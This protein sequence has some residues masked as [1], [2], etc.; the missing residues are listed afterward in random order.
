MAKPDPE[1]LYHYTDSS[2]LLG[3]LGSPRRLPGTHNHQ[4]F[5]VDEDATFGTLWATDA[6]YLNDSHEIVFGASILAD[7][8]DEQASVQGRT[9]LAAERL[10]ALA[11]DVRKSRFNMTRGENGR[12]A[13]PY[14]ACFCESGDLLSQWRGYGANGGGYAVGFRRS[15]LPNFCLLNEG[16]LKSHPEHALM[17]MYVE[18]RKV[19]YGKRA[20]R[21]G[22]EAFAGATADDLEQSEPAPIE[23]SWPDIF[24]LTCVS[25][26][27]SY[28]HKAFKEEAER[29]FVVNDSGI[30]PTQIEFRGSGMGLLP[31]VKMYFPLSH[32]G[33]S[34]VA[35]IV[36]GPGANGTLRKEAVKRLLRKIGST[37]TKVRLSGTPFR[38]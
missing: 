18:P 15:S 25:H 14:V 22:V 38:Q 29:R 26:L 2:G 11:D 23:E 37:E 8:L 10:R 21:A 6:R 32:Q 16:L 4:F 13:V 5:K 1:I 31:Y 36:V 7:K 27:A 19:G 9:P 17:Q 28:K 33:E 3:I 35:E 12:K 20:V 34:S 24:R 30:D